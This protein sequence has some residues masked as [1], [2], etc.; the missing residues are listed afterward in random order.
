MNH[1]EAAKQ[2]A[3]QLQE[4]IRK[5]P[6]AKTKTYRVW[7][8][9]PT[10]QLLSSLEDVEIGEGEEMEEMEEVLRDVAEFHTNDGEA[11]EYLGWQGGVYEFGYE[12]DGET[13]SLFLT[14]EEI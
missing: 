8:C 14:V 11:C 10:G 1:I 5:A 9:T 6:K 13:Q 12:W 4:K 2:M 7:K 3:A